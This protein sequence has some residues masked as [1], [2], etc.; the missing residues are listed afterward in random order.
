MAFSPELF[1]LYPDLY[2]PAP[3]TKESPSVLRQMKEEVDVI[4]NIRLDDFQERYERYEPI[5]KSI[6][7][8][9]EGVSFY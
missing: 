4:V 7:A 1:T 8:K 6:L 9:Y 2:A 5:R 3:F